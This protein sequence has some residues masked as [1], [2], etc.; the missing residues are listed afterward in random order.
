[1]IAKGRREKTVSFW[2]GKKFSSSYR[3]FSFPPPFLIWER[4]KNQWLHQQGEEL[5]RIGANGNWYWEKRGGRFIKD[6]EKKGKRHFPSSYYGKKS[7][8]PKLPCPIS[9]IF[10]LS[11]WNRSSRR[12]FP[13]WMF[14]RNVWK[15]AALLL[16][17]CL[18]NRTMN[19]V[20][21]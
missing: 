20:Q 19:R 15:K 13:Q 12:R 4:E 7:E 21:S 5:G 11:L 18:G 14:A 1:M 3:V 9:Q 17:C 8:L 10:F 16:H 2:Q 6:P